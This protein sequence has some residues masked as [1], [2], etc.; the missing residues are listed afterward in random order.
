[1]EEAEDA[2]AKAEG[3]EAEEAEEGG[4]EERPFKILGMS[5]I[6]GEKLTTQASLTSPTVTNMS[7][8]ELLSM[9]GNILDHSLDTFLIPVILNRVGGSF[10]WELLDDVH[11]SL[12]LILPLQQ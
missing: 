12:A 3:E 8:I 1:M 7:S 9:P 10:R 11:P 5:A 4:A 6:S 2:K